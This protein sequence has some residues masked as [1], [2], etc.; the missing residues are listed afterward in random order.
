MVKASSPKNLD[1]AIRA[2]YD[3]EMTVKSLKGGQTYKGPATRKTF[4]DKEGPSKAKPF[5]PPR[6]NQLDAAT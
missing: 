2:A 6:T 5:P 1:D 3:L 4:A